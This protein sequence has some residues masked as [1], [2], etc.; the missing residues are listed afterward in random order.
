LPKD[1]KDDEVQIKKL[2][3]ISG[4]MLQAIRKPRRTVKK[5]VDLAS[6]SE[7]YSTMIMQKLETLTR[8]DKNTEK[9]SRRNFKRDLYIFTVYMC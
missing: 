5:N 2:S 4:R 9:N 3:G 1:L 6:A 7:L 8:T